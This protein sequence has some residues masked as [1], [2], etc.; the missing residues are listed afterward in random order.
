[1]QSKLLTAGVDR[2]FGPQDR[3][4]VRAE[5]AGHVQNCDRTCTSA[6]CPEQAFETL[7]AQ[8]RSRLSPAPPP[9]SS[10]LFSP[11][12]LLQATPPQ[13]SSSYY[14]RTQ[15]EQSAESGPVERAV[16]DLDRHLRR[17][18]NGLHRQ[19]DDTGGGGRFAVV[20][21]ACRTTQNVE[22]TKRCRKHGL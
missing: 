14:G 1:M 20:V 5:L 13:F 15:Q 11:P 16:N 12:T 4:V 6:T 8:D 7:C 9:R 3:V 22:T 19:R 21:A 17:V 18:Q 10:T 2:E